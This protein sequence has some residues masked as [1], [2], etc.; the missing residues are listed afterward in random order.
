LVTQKQADFELFKEAINIINKGEHLTLEGLNKLV[1]IKA[2]MNK[3]LSDL[4]KSEFSL[5]PYPRPST[6]IPD[7]LDDY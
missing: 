6:R 1:A 7:R 4:L 5:Q 3:G 2:S